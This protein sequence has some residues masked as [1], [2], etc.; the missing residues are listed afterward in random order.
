M[1]M[2]CPKI[3]KFPNSN[4]PDKICL[5]ELHYVQ[6]VTEYHSF[7]LNEEETNGI[8]LGELLDT[9]PTVQPN[10]FQCETCGG[11]WPNVKALEA[12]VKRLEPA[13]PERSDHE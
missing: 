11:R 6:T 7:A 8:I 4:Q 5:G 2:L 9:E 13:E 10:Y 3:R 1:T 12:D